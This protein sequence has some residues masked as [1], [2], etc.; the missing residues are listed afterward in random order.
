MNW[1][2]LTAFLFFCAG[3]TIITPIFGKYIAFVY[4][5]P[6]RDDAKAWTSYFNYKPQ[7]WSG[8]FT[9]LMCFNL[10]CIAITFCILYYQKYLPL[11]NNLQNELSF[12][13]ALNAAISFTTGTF[14]QSHSPENDLSIF[15]HIFAIT[16][17]NFLSGGNA[18]AVFIAFTRG[19]I[20]NKNPYI[21]NFYQDLWTSLIYILLPLSFICGLFLISWSVPHNFVGALN[22]I[23]LSNQEQNI[24]MGPIAGQVAI[25]NLAAN[26]GS[27]MSAAAAHPFE[28]P[29]RSAIIFSIYMVLLLPVSLIFTYGYLLKQQKLSWS[30]Y[31]I[32]MILMF[33]SLWVMHLGET[34]YGVPLIMQGAVLED[35]FNYT[36][37]E[38]IYDKFPSLMWVLSIT[39]SS[40][41]AS[42]ACLENYSPL[43]TLIMFSNLTISKFILEGVSSGFLA[44]LIYLVIAVF[45][46]GLVSGRAN[47]FFGKQISVKEINYVVIVFL[48]MPIGV[49][50]FTSITLLLPAGR[51]LII[52]DGPQAITDIAF[53]FISTFSNN[54]AAFTG[55]NTANDYLNYMTALAMFLGRYPVI[56]YSLALSGSFASKKKIITQPKDQLR[57]DIELG[58]FLIITALLVGC[59][60][61]MPLMILG[62]L[63]EFI[64]TLVV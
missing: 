51:D 2:I 36:G 30:L 22:Y 54:G 52:Y 13:A 39:M 63:M 9:S 18:I 17:Q 6:K 24:F 38:L 45:L 7:T 1:Y 62:P 14:W 20:N 43:S 56:Y 35:D 59:I 31:I 60:S 10:V 49:L 28:A 41:G 15:S 42:N 57:F 58:I 37:K 19:I 12:A 4:T 32:I 55:I 64:N 29:T 33:G 8:Y 21:G 5:H 23:D 40:S 27:L 3:L 50:L 26:G 44:M 47:H 53:N 11:H 34:K 46:R 25:R 16:T 61:F 48:L